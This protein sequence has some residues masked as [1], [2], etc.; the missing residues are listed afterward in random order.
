MSAHPPTLVSREEWLS[1][2]KK[3]LIDEK[4][5]TKARDALT[6]QRSQLP[7]VKIEKEYHFD[8]DQG[9]KPLN[10]LFEDHRQLVVYH[11]M[12]GQDW[13]EGCPSCSFWCDHF[14]FLPAHLAARNTAFTCVSNAPIRKLLEYRSRMKWEFNWVSA[15]TSQFGTDFGVMFDDPETAPIGSYNYTSKPHGQECPGLTV[16]NKLSDGS[17]AHSYSTYGRGLDILNTAYHMLDMTPEGR[18]EEGLPYTMSWL[19]RRDDY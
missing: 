7:W 10:D 6:Y 13:D 15:Q 19:R 5:F 12:F 11:F 2:R 3:L 9:S 16:F 1:A 4:A 14:N 17:I 8:T 18:N